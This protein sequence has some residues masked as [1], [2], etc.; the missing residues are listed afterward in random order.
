MGKAKAASN[1][2]VQLNSNNVTVIDGN[3]NNV[4]TVN[5]SAPGTDV[6]V[7][8]ITNMRPVE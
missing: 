1:G 2:K 8:P 5:V 7:N 4:T 6:D 3:T